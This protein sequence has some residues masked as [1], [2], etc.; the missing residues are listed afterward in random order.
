MCPGCRSD[1]TQWT[2]CGGQG[3]SRNEQANLA[4]VVVGGGVM[5][6]RG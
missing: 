5:Y 3:E 2:I 4:R 6:W 1:G